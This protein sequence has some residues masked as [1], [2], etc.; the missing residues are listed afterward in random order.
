M[1]LLALSDHDTV[2]GVSEA[3]AAGSAMAC[4]SSP[5]SRSPRSMTAPMAP[6]RANCTSSAISST[7]PVRL[8]TERLAEFLADREQRTLRMA[9]ALRELGLD[10][11]ER[12][13]GARRADGQPIGRPHLAEAVLA[14]PPTPPDSRPR[15]STT[16][17]RSSGP[18]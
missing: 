4:A 5:R 8:L 14:A 1:E 2:S 11:D 7:T 18:T 13:L 10:L 12:E 16:S 3:L 15:A 17:A 9:A 6:G